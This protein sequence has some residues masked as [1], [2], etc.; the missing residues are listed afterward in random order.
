MDSRAVM[1]RVEVGAQAP[2]FTLKDEQNQEWT[3]SAHRGRN[4]VLVFYPLSFSRICTSELRE[5]SAASDRFDA[6]GAEVV[7][8]SVD[9]RHVQ[10]EFKKAEELHATLLADFHP[11]GAVAQLYGVYLDDLGF[12][13]RATFVI[14]KAGKVIDKIVTDVGT[15]RDM[16]GYLDALAACAA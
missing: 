4:I 2:D 16:D 11:K 1:E 6:A 3:L 12:A 13:N 9:S 8:I 5:L 15:A 14:D 7:G 10:R